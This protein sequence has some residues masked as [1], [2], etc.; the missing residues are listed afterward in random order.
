[1][2]LFLTILRT[3]MAVAS[4]L[5]VIVFTML[6]VAKLGRT[7]GEPASD[8]ETLPALRKNPARR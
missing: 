3:L 2:T 5:A 7:S 4:A 1:M 8:G 6:T